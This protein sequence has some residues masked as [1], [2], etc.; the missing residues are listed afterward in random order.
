MKEDNEW[1]VMSVKDT[2]VMALISALE[3][4]NK[5]KKEKK[6]DKF[7]SKDKKDS[8]DDKKELTDEEKLKRKDTKI[9]DWKKQAPKK[10]ESKT[11][12]KDGK[13]YHHCMKC[14]GGKGLWALYK[15]SDLIHISPLS[16]LFFGGL[17]KHSKYPT[18]NANSHLESM[19]I[20]NM[21]L[22][23][24]ESMPLVLEVAL[25]MILTATVSEFFCVLHDRWRRRILR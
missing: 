6:K 5:G 25:G 22:S 2:M 15:E 13:T 21:I 1:N 23:V 17:T 3:S 14:R 18:I 16:N 10:G 24:S 11:M 20:S 8:S 9:P 19:L 4:S 7:K 12:V